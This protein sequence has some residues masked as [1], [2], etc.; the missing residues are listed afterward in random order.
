MSKQLNASTS[1][2][3]ELLLASARIN[4]QRVEKNDYLLTAHAT[5]R[6]LLRSIGKQPHEYSIIRTAATRPAP[7][8]SPLEA[9]PAELRQHILTYTLDDHD[10][11]ATLA[12]P[13]LLSR[14]LTPLLLTSKT[15]NADVRQMQPAW[16]RRAAGARARLQ[17][18]RKPTAD[19]IT[20]L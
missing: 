6:E 15:L 16:T 18:A 8:K 9:L 5:H 4:A 11:D 12:T 14:A 2:W 10:D 1:I 19:L 13:P 7:Q 3:H 17:R 20:A